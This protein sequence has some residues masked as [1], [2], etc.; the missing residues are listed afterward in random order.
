M[1][2]RKRLF[3]PFQRPGANASRIACGE[4][5]IQNGL[6]GKQK[7]NCALHVKVFD[8]KNYKTGQTLLLADS[9][10]AEVEAGIEQPECQLL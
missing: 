3:L 9:A 5:R 4:G 7:L 2:V 8:F 1:T 6:K 10:C